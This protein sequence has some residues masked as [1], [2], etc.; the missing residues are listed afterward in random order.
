MPHTEIE[1]WCRYAFDFFLKQAWFIYKC[2]TYIICIEY[3]AEM[4]NIPNIDR[5]IVQRT[6]CT[7]AVYRSFVCEQCLP[8]DSRNIFILTK[9]WSQ[10]S[11]IRPHRLSSAV[12]IHCVQPVVDTHRQS[13]ASAALHDMYSIVYRAFQNVRQLD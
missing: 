7:G 9:N 10:T 13:S 5:I 2:H 6:G 1:I 12:D 8:V 11:A 4:L 3:R